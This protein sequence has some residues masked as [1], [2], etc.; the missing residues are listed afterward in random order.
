VAVRDV[1][2]LLAERRP[3]VLA[4]DDV[5]WLDAASSGALAFA[6]R[7]LA[8]SPVLLLLA[9]RV[10][11]GG[12]LSELER[13]LPAERVQRLPVGPLSVG[14]L[15]RLLQDHF[16]RPFPRQTLLRI[17][18]R[19][20]GNPFFALELARV[21]DVDVHP[22]EPLPVPESLD[23]LVRA[24]LSGL[25]AATREALALAAASGTPSESLLR[26]AG[27]A[28]DAL[29]PA[30]EAHV[31]DRENG[32]IRFTHPL[33]SSCLYRE[34]GERR[35]SIH[36]RIAGIVDDPLLRARHL[37]LSSEAPDADVAAL[38][39]DAANLAADRGAAAVAAELAEQATRLTPRDASA[40]RVRRVLGAARAQHAAGEWT[41]A[42]TILSDL[43]AQSDIC[44]PRAEALALLSEF[45]GLDRAVALLEEALREAQS[46]PVR[47][48]SAA[49]PRSSQR[50]ARTARSPPRSSSGSARSRPTSPTS[51]QSSACA[52]G[53][54]SRGRSGHTSKVQGNSRFQA[55]RRGLAS[56]ACGA[57]S[58]RRFSPA[59]PPASVG[60]VN[61][62][63][64]RPPRR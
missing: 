18:E 57:T 27:V 45:E 62:G 7:R 6:L 50:A 53:P 60:R 51:T 17:H 64:A 11:D 15:H 63:H 39:D 40:D 24:R 22:L 48:R 10:I 33:L 59:A 41:R 49:S 13:V 44:P 4:V 14:A 54:S 46:Q 34:L 42:R 21:M 23:E 9:R 3:V 47:P 32:T 43:L 25:P 5:Q 28:A 29:Q 38:L 37:A 12:E 61:S 20:G 1:L 19:S 26:R 30:V 52:R 35:R 56:A 58:S 8:A 2:H 36:R 16:T 31:I 55:E